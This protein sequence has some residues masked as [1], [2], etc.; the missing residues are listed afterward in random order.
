[1]Q[2]GGSTNNFSPL[3]STGSVIPNGDVLAFLGITGDEVRALRGNRMSIFDAKSRLIKERLHSLNEETQD[4]IV[5]KILA[6]LID[7]YS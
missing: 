3:S 5:Q 7:Q 4:P 1:M 6:V 2:L